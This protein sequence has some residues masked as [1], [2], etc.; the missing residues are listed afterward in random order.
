MSEMPR[1]SGYGGIHKI[2]SFGFAT[3]KGRN[4]GGHCIANENFGVGF[5]VGADVCRKIGKL[6]TNYFNLTVRATCAIAFK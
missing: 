1:A 3:L 5:S 4:F 6:K 2:T